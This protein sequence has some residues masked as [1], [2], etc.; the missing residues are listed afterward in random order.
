MIE[1]LTDREQEILQLQARR[2]TS[3][4]IAQELF[5]SPHTVNKHASNLYGKLQ[6]AG[7]RQAVAKAR[8]LGIL[9]PK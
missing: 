7:R 4:E 5:I 8:M 6:V 1:P 3:K 2:L 9:P